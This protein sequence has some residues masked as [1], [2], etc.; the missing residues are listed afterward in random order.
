[1]QD[2]GLLF[3]THKRVVQSAEGR[4]FA[5]GDVHACLEQLQTLLDRLNFD[6]T[7]DQA[8]FV[9][10]L[11]DRGHKHLEVFEFVLDKPYFH[12][13][14]GNHEDLLV[15]YVTEAQ[16]IHPEMLDYW[17]KDDGQW[18]KSIAKP[19]LSEIAERLMQ[20]A[21]YVVEAE[22]LDGTRFGITHA[23]YLHQSWFNLNHKM[24]TLFY[25]QMMWRRDTAEAEPGELAG[26]QGIDFTV[27]GHT[28]FREPTLNGNAIFIDTGACGDGNL[29]ALH[30][31]AFAESRCLQSSCRAS[32]DTQL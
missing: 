25:R 8:I 18:T 13:V 30:L 4:L 29:T 2:K 14:A 21:S 31:D 16:S 20:Q 1:M 12:L 27:H 11:A 3:N 5:I 28:V 22:T 32:R 26:I 19:I 15:D 6:S 9:G 24:D 23:G 10:D 17:L 7:T